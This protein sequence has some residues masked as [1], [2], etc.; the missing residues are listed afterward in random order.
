MM[1]TPETCKDHS[2]SYFNSLTAAAKL[3]TAEETE[4]FGMYK[5]GLPVYTLEDVSKHATMK[6]RV[7]VSY[8]HGV[9]DITD[10][11]PKHPGKST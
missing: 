11:I 4:E 10:L 8:K 7:W 1:I 5:E 6:D 2:L 9:Y 3:E